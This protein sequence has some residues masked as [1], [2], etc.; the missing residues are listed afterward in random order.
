MTDL[1]QALMGALDPGAVQRMG[2]QLG[3]DPK[4]TEGAIQAA[5]PLLLG[6]MGRNASDPQGAQSLHRAATRDHAG[7]DFGDVLGSVLGGQG[8][9]AGTA[10]LGHIFG[11]RQQRAS[12]GLGK[13]AGLDGAQ[14]SQLLAML[15]PLVMNMLGKQTQQRDLGAGGLGDLLG[16][17]VRSAQGGSPDL[18]SAVLDRDGDGDVDFADLMQAGGGLLG[19]MF[20]KR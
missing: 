1:T 2:Q 17:A 8:Q 12:T 20:G 7:L 16:G 6:A 18:V 4:H 19:S 13:I 14:A 11:A 10:I 3:L 9:Q 15:A 5:L